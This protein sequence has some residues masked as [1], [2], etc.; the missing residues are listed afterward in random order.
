MNPSLPL[1]SDLPLLRLRRRHEAPD[2]VKNYHKLLVV[3]VIFLLQLVKLAS[4]FPI[5][6]GQLAHLHECSHDGNIYL[7]GAVAIK[8]AGEHRHTLFGENVGKILA[9]CTASTF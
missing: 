6:S 1:E 5:G 8:D 4:N 9:V 7:H 3:F 2:G